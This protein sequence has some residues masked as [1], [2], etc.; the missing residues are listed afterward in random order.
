MVVFGFIFYSFPAGFMMYI[1][2][3]SALGI[4]ESKI[5]KAEL[6]RDEGGEAGPG[7]AGRSVAHPMGP[8]PARSRR[9]ED[10]EPPKGKRAR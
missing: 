6:G 4:L 3:S 9:S 10:E 1:M 8:Y 5:I 2:T 7:G